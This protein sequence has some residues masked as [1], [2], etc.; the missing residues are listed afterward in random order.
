M[1]GI[2]GIIAFNS[3]PNASQM[4]SKMNDVLAHR[5]PNGSGR[6]SSYDEKIHFGHRRL[7]IIDLTELAAQPMLSADGRF[8]ITY[9]GEIYNFK[10][11]RL[12]CEKL[13]S[14]FTSH[15]DTEV[16]IECFRHWRC[17]AFK[18]FKG[19][20]ALAIHDKQS[21]SIIFSRDPFGIKPLYYA[22]YQGNLFFASEPKALRSLYDSFNEVDEVS[23]I[24]FIEHGYLDRG[25]WTFFKNIKRFPHAHY[26]EVLLDTTAMSKLLFQRYW[27]PPSDRTTLTMEDAAA[28]L[29]RL[30]KTSV[31]LHLRSDVP[32]GSCLSGGLDSSSIVCIASDLIPADK[33]LNTFTVH[34]PNHHDI[35]ESIWAKKIIDYTGANSHFIEPSYQ[36][37]VNN[38][39]PLL[40]VQ[41]EPFG[42]TS[43][44]AQYCIFKMIAKTKVKVI[45]DGQGSDEML[46]G[47]H[48]F[49]PQFLQF[50]LTQGQ[51]IAYFQEGRA[52]KKYYKT[53][54]SLKTVLKSLYQRNKAKN[55]KSTLLYNNSWG[56]D[57]VDTLEDRMRNILQYETSNFDDTL[58]GLLCETNIPQLLR[59]EDRNSMAFSIES[60]VPFLE[61]ELV[62]FI[63]SLPARLKINNGKT[64]AVLREAIKGIVPDEV[65]HRMDKLGFPT[66]EKEWIKKYCGVDVTTGGGRCWREL[67]TEKWRDSVSSSIGQKQKSEIKLEKME[68]V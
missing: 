13:G 7:A 18:K 25:D 3:L 9:N 54:M 47:Y 27:S 56:G 49:V 63:L 30:L 43:I 65:R 39:D 50:L 40:Q 1:C 37:F 48:G 55:S 28:E 29:A 64:K 15:S 22:V 6:W 23:E 67:V 26:A 24:L 59:Y 42:S 20:W 11:L 33:S 61:P 35:D 58:S 31:Q 32:V 51:L 62:T 5:G 12:E 38:F 4:V 17:E 44:F 53:N 19:M 41:D 66:P 34:Y 14:H 68:V 60:R 21:N 8:V 52:L 10:E 2:A 36:D 16:I 46:A 57:C 45:L